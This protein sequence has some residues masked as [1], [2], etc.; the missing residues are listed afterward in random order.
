MKTANFPRAAVMNV[1]GRHF[2]FPV[3]EQ[4]WL[5]SICDH[6]VPNATIHYPF[7]EILFM[8]FDD[9]SEEGPNLA[10]ISGEQA[11]EIANFI[12]RARAEKKNVWVNCHAGICRSGAIVSLLGDLGWEVVKHAESPGR[13][14]NHLVYDKV[15]KHFPEVRQSWDP[16]TKSD[17]IWIFYQP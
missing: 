17:D 11:A 10:S 3:T 4:D 5:I 2:P 1:A 7:D 14:P 13:I 9:V 8:R 6:D 12:K 15:R 16:P